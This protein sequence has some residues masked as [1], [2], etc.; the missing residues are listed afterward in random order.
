MNLCGHRKGGPIEFTV[1]ARHAVRLLVAQRSEADAR[2][3]VGQCAGS[4]V[5]IGSLLHGDGPLSQRIDGSSGGP[6]NGSA[7]RT[8]RA[9]WVMSIR[10]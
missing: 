7:R 6:G 5:V 10:R 3:L 4:F 2:E 8:D 9:P 1:Q